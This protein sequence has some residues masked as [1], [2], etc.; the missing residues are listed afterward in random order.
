MIKLIVLDVDGC[1]SDGKITYTTSGKE[2]K[3]FNVK[4][5]LAIASWIKM[6]RE[7]IIIT[8][9]K[10][11]IIKRRA[12][13]LKLSAYYEGIKDKLGC[14]NEYIQEKG[15]SLDE[16]AAIGDDLN[17]LKMLQ[18]VGYSYTPNDGAKLVKPYV[19]AILSNSGGNGA[20]REMIE[21]ICEKENIMSEFIDIWR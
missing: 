4:D 19:N 6:G 15:I 8:G 13:E 11:T 20:V 21:D 16:I 10:S 9:R 17:D 3:S 1:L 12:E 7:A 5:G 14:L 2:L 18:N